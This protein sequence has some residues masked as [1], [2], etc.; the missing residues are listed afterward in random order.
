MTDDINPGICV[1][2]KHMTVVRSDRGVIF[3][4]CLLS[5]Q[6]H[7]F[8]KYPRLPVRVCKGWAEDDKESADFG[9]TKQ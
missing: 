5:D 1:N 4:R 6:D 7:H 3:Y 2:C 8:P 9:D